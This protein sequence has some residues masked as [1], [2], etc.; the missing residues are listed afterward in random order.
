MGLGSLEILMLIPLLFGANNGIGLPIGMPPLA[1]NPMMSRIAPEE[2]YLFATWAGRDKPNTESNPTEKWMAQ[3][4][5]G[6]FSR[7]LELSLISNDTGK[8]A[9]MDPRRLRSVKHAIKLIDIVV[10]SPGA[11]Y[12]QDDPDFLSDMFIPRLISEEPISRLNGG[13]V[14]APGKRI[15]EFKK[16]LDFFET[17]LSNE[18]LLKTKKIGEKTFHQ[19]AGPETRY[20]TITWGFS[21]EYFVFAFG[22]NS[23][24]PLL[25]NMGTPAPEWLKKSRAKFEIN[26]VASF[27]VIDAKN[28]EKA[29]K[30]HDHAKQPPLLDEFGVTGLKS[31]C[32][33]SGLDDRGFISESHIEFTEEPSGIFQ[34]IDGQPIPGYLLHKIP[35]EKTFAF[36]SR[37]SP[38]DTFKL[39]KA[40]I[41]KQLG[42]NGIDD[43]IDDLEETTG[44]QIERDIVNA[45]SGYIYFYSDSEILDNLECWML[46]FG[47][48]NEMT[49]NPTI[50]KLTDWLSQ[51]TGEEIRSRTIDGYKIYSIDMRFSF[52][53][54]KLSWCVADREFLIAPSSVDIVEHLGREAESEDVLANNATLKHLLLDDPASRP[55]LVA[56]VDQ[57]EVLRKLEDLL[58][59]IFDN[60]SLPL[61]DAGIAKPNDVVPPIAKLTKDIEPSVLIVVRT[62][63]G[64]RFVQRQTYPGG[65]L[66]TTLAGLGAVR[67]VTS[68]SRA[69]EYRRAKSYRK[70]WKVAVANFEYAKVHGGIPP[71]YSISPDGK[72]L[73]S[74]RVHVLPHLGHRDLY[75][76]FKLDEPWDSEHNKALIGKMPDV[77]A[78][79]GELPS[80]GKTRLLG[81]ATENGV[82]VGPENETDKKGMDFSPDNILDEKGKTILLV[83]VGPTHAVEWTK[84]ADFESLPADAPVERFKGSYHDGF[85]VALC[86]RQVEFLPFDIAEKHLRALLNGNDG[87]DFDVSEILY[88]FLTNGGKTLP[89]EYYL[90]DK[91]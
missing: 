39:I 43:V 90:D 85:T 7:I 54:S 57:A 33:I 4:S 67:V 10:Q 42:D 82:F 62:E 5:I 83:E 14:S 75:E 20:Q 64:F 86:N 44:I 11:I 16:E 61:H 27:V 53:I 9:S 77:F 78:F 50:D 58:D 66:G 91:D 17:L 71:A 84:P 15:D 69:S 40:T 73:L 18:G 3:E 23:M 56:S 45:L 1:E 8:S 6:Q 65:T 52:L 19:I 12:L 48:E 35:G 89:S 59:A 81:N 30:A 41:G 63:T 51:V 36:A 46:S 79:P 55:I 25:E 68:I 47:V 29:F 49:F 26:R 74:W 32:W 37:Y 13:F 80:D 21:D 72:K 60:Q 34:L 88:P 31:I 28:F 87:V 22:E 24:E 70:A 38:A 2:C 76:Q